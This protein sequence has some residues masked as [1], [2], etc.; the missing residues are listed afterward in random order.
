[1]S[2]NIASSKTQGP[3]LD[4]PADKDGDYHWIRQGAQASQT[5]TGFPYRAHIGD[6]DF[7]DLIAHARTV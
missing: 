4:R 1:V 5:P 7:D 2:R 3:R 6:G